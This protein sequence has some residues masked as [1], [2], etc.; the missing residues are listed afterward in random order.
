MNTGWTYWP[1][2]AK[3]NLFLRITGRRDDG[4]HELSTAF[5]FL[6]HMDAIGLRVREDGLIG[7][8]ASIVGVSAEQ[9]LTTRAARLLQSVLGTP[10]GADIAVDKRIPLGAGLGGGSSNAATTLVGLNLLWKG[11]LTREQLAALGLKLGADVPVFVRGQAAWAGGVGEVL[12]PVDF[13]EP[14]Y[15][16]LHP[17]C[18]VSTAAVFASSALTRDSVPLKIESFVSKEPQDGGRPVS[19]YAVLVRS[20]ND[21]EEVVRQQY[22]QVDAAFRWLSRFGLVRMTGTGASLFLPLEDEQTGHRLLA[23]FPTQWQGLLARGINRSP[24][25]SKLDSEIKF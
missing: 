24:L 23:Q 9:D 5:Q 10:L 19:P 18:H 11:G 8:T 22:P 4:Y 2:P 20:G 25:L 12:T 15:L 16:I 7:R 6:D 1:A 13:E 17:G 14:W 3:L 21:C